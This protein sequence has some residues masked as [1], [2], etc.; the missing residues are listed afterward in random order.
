MQEVPRSLEILAT[1]CR[2][3]ATSYFEDRVAREVERILA[4]AATPGSRTSSATS[5][6]A[7]P[8]ATHQ[9]RHLPARSL[10]SPTW[11]TRG[12]RSSKSA[13]GG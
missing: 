5:S 6:L 4:D 9:T 2:H 7:S 8:D 13:A 11:T 10:S 12:S 3:P 1:L